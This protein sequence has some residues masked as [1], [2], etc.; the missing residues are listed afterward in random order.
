MKRAVL[1]NLI[2]IMVFSLLNQIAGL[3]KSYGGIL[4]DRIVA[5]VNGEV[6]TWSEL[7]KVIELEGKEFLKG[8]TGEERER[9]IKELEKSF[10]NDLI[11]MKLQLQ[12]ARRIGLDVS[13]SET[14]GAINEIKK[15]YNLTDEAF[16]NSLKAE[17][18]T[19]EEYKTRLAEQILLSKVVNFEVRNNIIISDREIEEYYEANKEKYSE[20]EKVRIRQIFFAPPED[21]A[22]RADIEAKAEEVIERIKK[23]EDFAKLASEFSEDPS[24]EF[25]G[26]LGY[27]SRGSILKE[28]EEIA[29]G[30]KTGEVSKPFWSSKGLHIIKLEDRIEGKD[31]EEVR[32]EIKEIL[33]ERAF[34]LRYDEWIK[35]LREKAYIE[36]KL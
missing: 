2:I 35:K 3:E 22:K 33:F 9:K 5:T 13:D 20:K 31:I 30:L 27:V 28:I 34:K 7:R 4:L 15:K 16:I 29:F 12:E 14:E 25:G 10:L 26:D 19:L 23:G 36:I 1:L 6:I 21:E 32:E 18:F 17:G 24:R 8:T 11:D